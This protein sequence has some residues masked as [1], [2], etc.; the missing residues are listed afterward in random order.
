MSERRVA[1]DDHRATIEHFLAFIP[2]PLGTVVHV[3]AHA[4]EEVEP[5][6]HHGAERIVLVE[7]NPTSYEGLLR[8]FALDGDVEVV[9]AAVTDHDGTERLL[10]HTNA[11]GGTESA[12]LLPMKRLGEIVPTMTTKEAVD[13]PS[14]TIDTLL[15]RLA[16]EPSS[17]G[18]LVLD[19][20]G[21]EAAAL[22]G[23]ARTLSAV[24]AVLTEVALIDLYDGASREEDVERLLAAAGMS[25]REGLDY[26]L[27][28]GERRFR[29]WGD[30]LFVR[31][32][33][34]A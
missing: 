28:E 31:A 20:Q 32:D 5:Y 7:A 29:A 24:A 18:L 10:L 17:V 19:I 6:R 21:A 1:P 11:G 30:R 3:G 26:E 23:A 25:S 22:R 15:A 4:G 13:V 12:S 33:R 34:R 14:L 27:Y 2:R 16:V 8:E 9:H